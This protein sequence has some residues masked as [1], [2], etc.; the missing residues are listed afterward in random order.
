MDGI[1]RHESILSTD[2]DYDILDGA[3]ADGDPGVNND[4]HFKS[5]CRYGVLCGYSVFC[6]ASNF[7]CV[8]V[9]IHIYS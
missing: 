8:N 2:S 5:E 9:H 4:F 3:D 1:Q 7:P 6:Y